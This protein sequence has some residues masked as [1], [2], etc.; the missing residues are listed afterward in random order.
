MTV[1]APQT[2][3]IE[4]ID[5]ARGVAL[6]AMATYHFSWDLESFGYLDPG[7][8]G[9]GPLKWYARGIASSFLILVGVS[10]VL[11]HGRG[12]RWE[13]FG[14]RLGMVAGAALAITVATYFATPDTFI[15]FGILHEIAVASVLGLAFLRLPWPALAALAALWIS[16]PWWGSSEFFSHPALVWL[17]L[18]PL[19]PRSNDFVPLFPWFSAVLAGMAAGRMMTGSGLAERL[20]ANPPAKNT[21]TRCLRFIG[22]HSLVFYLVHQP[23]LIAGVY[24]FSLL[25]PPAP[26]QPDNLFFSSCVQSCAATHAEETCAVFCDCALTNLK[27]QDL[28]ESVYKGEITQESDPRVAAVSQQCSIE[29]GMNGN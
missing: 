9:T 3:R 5:L 28:F 13:G 22:R 12:I 6:I 24:L 20:A 16:V 26:A 25:S 11:A 21:L 15:F 18:S 14:K 27:A 7:A 2:R 29:A 19:P 23:V 10:L 1:T 4:W 17:G 8:A